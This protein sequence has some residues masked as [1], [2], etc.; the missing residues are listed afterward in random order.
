MGDFFLGV[1]CGTGGAFEFKLLGELEE[2]GGGVRERQREGIELAKRAGAYKGRKRKFSPERTAEL[3]RRLA[4]GEEKT[5]LAREFGV[6]RATIYRY[7]G[8][9]AIEAAAVAKKPM[10]PKRARSSSR[11]R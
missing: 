5:S 3:S 9:A 1:G 7:V 2:I 11:A 10:I 6:N 4:E 8:W